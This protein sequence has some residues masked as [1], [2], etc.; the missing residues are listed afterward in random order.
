VA[1][2]ENKHQTV[3]SLETGLLDANIKSGQSLIWENSND[4]E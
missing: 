2:R 3:V 4:S 1:D